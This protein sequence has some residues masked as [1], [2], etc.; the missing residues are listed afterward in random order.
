MTDTYVGAAHGPMN[1]GPGP[2]HNH[3]YAATES[4][5]RSRPRPRSFSESDRDHLAERFVPPS[6][7]QEARRLLA[8]RHTVLLDGPCASGRRTAALMLLHEL[9]GTGGSLHELP[10]TPDD[11]NGSPL[12]PEDIGEGDRLL[13]DLSGAEESRYIAF[14]GTL[15]DFRTTLI[16]RGARLVVV[17][18]RDLAYLLRSELRHLRAELGRPDPLRVLASHLKCDGVPFTGADLTG[19]DLA[20]ALLPFRLQDVATLA[21]RVREQWRRSTADRGFPDWL[22]SA[23][24]D[25]AQ[26]RHARSAVAL[27]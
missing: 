27:A 21:D 24:A 18:P 14:Q 4:R 25:S 15:P 12:D 6:G 5:L 23:L 17:L 1:S 19:P 7:F 16:A 10:D 8:D 22:R 3:Y 11:G 9:P 13:L 20:A 26:D 2:Q